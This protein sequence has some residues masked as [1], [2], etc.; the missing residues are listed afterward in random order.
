MDPAETD[1]AYRAVGLPD[2]LGDPHHDPV[3]LAARAGSLAVALTTHLENLGVRIA[4]LDTPDDLRAL[5]NR[6]RI[7]QP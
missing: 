1:A 7:P 5:P 3:A 2:M 4:V 6:P